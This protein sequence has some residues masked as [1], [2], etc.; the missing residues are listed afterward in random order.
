MINF[1]DDSYLDKLG[2]IKNGEYREYLGE[3]VLDLL[4]ARLANR[5][6]ELLDDSQ[7]NEMISTPDNRKMSWLEKNVP[8]FENIIGEEL[9]SIIVD[10]KAVMP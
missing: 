7:L 8:N 9:E 5:V 10:M 4:N 1:I 6:M 3:K 2:A